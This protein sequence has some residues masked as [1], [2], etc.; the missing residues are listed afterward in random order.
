[1]SSNLEITKVGADDTSVIRK[2]AE[3]TWPLTYGDILSPSQIDYMMNLFYSDASLRQQIT[4]QQHQF[5]V[6]SIDSTPVG[7]ASYNLIDN[8]GTYKLQK[9]YVNP[10]IQGRGLGKALIDYIVTDIKR[11]NAACLQLNVNRHNKAKSF[12]EKLGF[13][14][15]REEDIDIGNEFW[16]NDYVMEKKL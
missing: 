6:A 10:S 13:S 2:L 15:I 5:V 8:N 9:L 14:V 1:M 12:Y 3:Q 11:E 16:M 4:S 7:F